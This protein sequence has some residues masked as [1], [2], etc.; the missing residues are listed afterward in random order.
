MWF[1]RRETNGLYRAA[2]QG[3]NVRTPRIILAVVA[4][5]FAASRMPA[6]DFAILLS[7]GGDEGSA[8]KTHDKW[9]PI[10]SVSWAGGKARKDATGNLVAPALKQP[11]GNE[12][13]VARRVHEPVVLTIPAEDGSAELRKALKKD[14]KLGTIRLRDGDR[15][16]ILHGAFV[17]SV[18]RKGAT[19]TIS[20][21]Y[22]KIENA[23]MPERARA[24][25][26]ATESARAPD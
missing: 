8:S 7:G 21:N 11:S 26:K 22:E 12:K 4:M 19:E 13:T 20:L 17:A 10:Q 9:I 2:K 6:P 3:I 5:T 14:R 15:E 25:I 23:R 24:R 16:L 18:V 1:D